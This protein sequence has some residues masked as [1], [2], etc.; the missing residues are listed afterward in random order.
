VPGAVVGAVL[1][2]MAAIAFRLATEAGIR[3]ASGVTTADPRV[4][5]IGESVSAVV[6]TALWA[7]LASI[8][9]LLGGELNAL[10]A[11]G[12]AQ[13]AARPAPRTNG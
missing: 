9:I 4:T 3:F 13:L 10:L 7:Y 2:I 5:L 1:W 11:A 12:K 8:S 6:A